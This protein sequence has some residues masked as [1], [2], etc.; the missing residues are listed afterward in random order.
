MSTLITSNIQGVQNIKY[1]ASTTA[2]NISSGG[3]VTKPNHPV[4][5]ASLLAVTSL[6]GTTPFKPTRVDINVG[7]MYD[8]S[9]GRATA[10]IAGA[11][12]FHFQGLLN[13]N[14]RDDVDIRFYL[15]GN[16]VQAASVY[17]PDW[18]SSY[19]KVNMTGIISLSVNDY[20]TVQTQPGGSADYSFYGDNNAFQ[21]SSGSGHSGFSGFLIG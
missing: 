10:P 2:L 18:G 11:Y 20:V 6:A 5:S 3:I 13:N 12:F 8:S 17:E 7:S 15:N 16:Q 21:S 19:R 1:D 14:E 9:T 4:F